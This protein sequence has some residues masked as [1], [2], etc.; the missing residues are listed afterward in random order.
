M[1]SIQELHRIQNN[2]KIV[3]K[4]YKLL[5]DIFHFVKQEYKTNTFYLFYRTLRIGPV[6]PLTHW[7]QKLYCVNDL[8]TDALLNDGRQTVE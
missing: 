5:E 8:P 4:V 6:T 1:N 7:K 3:W 2:H